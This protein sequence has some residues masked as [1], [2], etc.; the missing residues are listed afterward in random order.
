MSAH[1]D[2]DNADNAYSDNHGISTED[3]YIISYRVEKDQNSHK[4]LENIETVLNSLL[5]P[6]THPIFKLTF[7]R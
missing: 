2:T 7:I 6:S 4:N 3:G 5:F 1:T